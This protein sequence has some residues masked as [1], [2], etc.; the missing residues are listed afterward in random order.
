M[1]INEITEKIIGCAIEVH[2][3]L[4]RCLLESAYQA[5]LAYEMMRAGLYFEKEKVLPVKY[6]DI[7]LEVGYRCDFLVENA[8]IVECK[9][10]KELTA[11][12]TA[13]AIHYLHLTNC[14]VALLINFHA[15]KLVDGVRRV[16]NNFDPES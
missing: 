3:T 14:R 10:V 15:P 13:Q 2:R 12:D 11:A 6:K 7:I 4:G 8:V 5:A 16:V 9:A 1:Q